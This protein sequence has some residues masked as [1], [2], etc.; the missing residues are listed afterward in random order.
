M[1]R[2]CLLLIAPLLGCGPKEAAPDA[3]A[4]A[5]PSAACAALGPVWTSDEGWSVIAST[6]LD[7]DGRTDRLLA[8]G[9]AGDEERNRKLAALV[10]CGETEHRVWQGKGYTL[11]PLGRRYE[12][13]RML[14]LTE[15]SGRE[16]DLLDQD[17]VRAPTGYHQALAEGQR[18]G[19]P[20]FGKGVETL[21]VTESRASLGGV[22]HQVVWTGQLDEDRRTDLVLVEEASGSLG[23]QTY[24]VVFGCDGGLGAV[25]LD[26][27]LRSVE[28]EPLDAGFATL[29][30]TFATMEGS[31][32]EEQW[33]LARPEAGVYEAFGED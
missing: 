20:V 22:P 2:I 24:R 26:E 30:L 5:D 27:V 23:G 8:Q 16:G 10:S 15:W 28:V 29:K 1:S 13:W 33:I 6:D 25:A 9:G 4:T 18:L 19:C 3:L 32:R 14:R 17:L 11:H 7:G 12:G 31:S 21:E